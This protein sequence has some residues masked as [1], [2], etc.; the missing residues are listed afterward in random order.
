MKFSLAQHVK[1]LGIKTHA[2]GK[3]KKALTENAKLKEALKEWEDAWALIKQ[4]RP[5]FHFCDEWDGLPIDKGEPEFSACQ[6]F[7]RE[8]P[9]K[10]IE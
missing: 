5:Y 2:R 7:P 4:F 6:C 9:R 3:P 8:K 10:V 1:T